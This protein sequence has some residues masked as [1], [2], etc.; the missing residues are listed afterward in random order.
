MRALHLRLLGSNHDHLGPR[1]TDMPQGL[2]SAS[3]SGSSSVPW[4]R[5]SAASIRSF[6][7]GSSPSTLLATSGAAL[8]VGT[9]A[10][11]RTSPGGAMN[12]AH[13]S[14]LHGTPSQLRANS[15]RAW[16]L[17]VANSGMSFDRGLCCGSRCCSMAH[18]VAR[19]KDV[20][21]PHAL[22]GSGNDEVTR[23]ARVS[24][25]RRIAV[26]IRAYAPTMISILV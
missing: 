4:R 18:A 21:G 6:I 16:T 25:A 7:N 19:L 14:P 2:A 5:R 15:Q 24:A 8:H 12:C 3:A 20:V 11:I 9:E 26:P 10:A 17:I 1:A 23:V 22:L 13:G